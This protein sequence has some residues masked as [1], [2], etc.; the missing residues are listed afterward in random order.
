[1]VFDWDKAAN[2]INE[3]QPD[4]AFAGL[5]S[6]EEYTQGVIYKE[7]MP[8]HDEYT[9]LASTWATPQI[10]LDGIAHD[11]YV[12]ESETEWGPD[13]KWPESALNIISVKQNQKIT[14]AANA[15]V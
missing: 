3:H 9:Y 4:I 12:M 5:E 2:L 11:C 10:V 7:N 13:T 8:I 1:M 6:D 15:K 14:R